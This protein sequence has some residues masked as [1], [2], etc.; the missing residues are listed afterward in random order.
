VQVVNLTRLVDNDER[1]KPLDAELLR[2]PLGLRG[3]GS[4]ASIASITNLASFSVAVRGSA[5][6]GHRLALE[7]VGP[8]HASVA[9][10]GCTS[11]SLV[12]EVEDDDLAAQ[13]FQRIVLPSTSVVLNWP[14]VC[15]TFARARPPQSCISNTSQWFL[16]WLSIWLTKPRRFGPCPSSPSARLPAWRADPSPGRLSCRPRFSG[17]R[18]ACWRRSRSRSRW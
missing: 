4:S 6:D 9:S 11:H 18:S 3:W 2:Q 12:P 16:S 5:E 15:A 1:R 10:P 14:P 7:V 13:P 8:A 17:R